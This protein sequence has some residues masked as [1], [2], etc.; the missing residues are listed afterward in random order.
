VGRL[1]VVLDEHHP[2]PAFDGYAVTVAIVA[3]NSALIAFLLPILG[4][5][6]ADAERRLSPKM[7]NY[8]EPNIIE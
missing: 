1:G 6:W 3:H 5:G 4:A 2:H 7:H 8:Q